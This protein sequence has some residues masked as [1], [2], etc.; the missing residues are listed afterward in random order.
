MLWI[1][2]N[3]KISQFFLRL[4]VHIPNVYRSQIARISNPICKEAVNGSS[5][6]P[7]IS[8][9]LTSTSTIGMFS[10]SAMYKSST[11]NALKERK[12]SIDNQVNLMNSYQR[13]TCI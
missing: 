1:S 12:I 10:F 6:E 2:D 4:I 9:Q 8:S 13:S 11:S 3:K 7:G 5:F